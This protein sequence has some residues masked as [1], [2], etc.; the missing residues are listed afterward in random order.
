MRSENEHVLTSTA[1]VALAV[2]EDRLEAADRAVGHHRTDS[3][4]RLEGACDV[5]NGNL[6]S[7]LGR[8]GEDT[9]CFVWGADKW[10]FAVDV[11][12]RLDSR[13]E[14]LQMLIRPA[15]TDQQ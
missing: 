8:G 2:G 11:N 13:K 10:L 9:I 12:P 15:R 7:R 6:Y 3:C 5:G 14:H 1:P 4:H